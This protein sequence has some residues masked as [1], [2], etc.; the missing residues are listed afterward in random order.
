[1]AE[2]KAKQ[3]AANGTAQLPIGNI[4]LSPGTRKKP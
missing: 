2:E 3:A 1:M 4:G